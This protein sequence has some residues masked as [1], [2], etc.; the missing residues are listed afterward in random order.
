MI[1]VVLYMCVCSVR[2]ILIHAW[3]TVTTITLAALWQYLYVIQTIHACGLE[4]SSTSIE[5]IFTWLT[6]FI[7]FN[8][9][10]KKLAIR[11]LR[12]LHQ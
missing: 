10:C 9:T 2:I 4:A 5:L 8:E 11:S 7:V 3:P 1:R 12:V 6:M